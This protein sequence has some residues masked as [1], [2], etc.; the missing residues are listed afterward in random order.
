MAR[1][2]AVTPETVAACDAGSQGPPYASVSTMTPDAGRP[3]MVET[4]RQPSRSL[5]TT[6][7]GRSKKRGPS[8]PALGG[9]RQGWALC[10]LNRGLGLSPGPARHDRFRRDHRV[11]WPHPAHPSCGAR[12]RRAK[13]PAPVQRASPARP[14]GWRPDRSGASR[15]DRCRSAPRAP[16]PSSRRRPCSDASGIGR[17]PR[18]PDGR[19]RPST[20]TPPAEDD[21]E[22]ASGAGPSRAGALCA[23]WPNAWPSKKGGGVSSPRRRVEPRRGPRRRLGSPP[24]GGRTSDDDG[25]FGD[26]RALDLGL[27]LD[28][29]RRLCFVARFD[30]PAFDSFRQRQRRQRAR[31][32]PWSRPPARPKEEKTSRLPV[33]VRSSCTMPCSAACVRNLL[34]LAKP[35][36]ASSNRGRRSRIFRFTSESRTGSRPAARSASSASTST[37]YDA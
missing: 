21:S 20:A 17:W 34:N 23:T 15:R 2:R 29:G 11:R 28:D 16:R 27:R 10:D 12:S 19:P 18:G 8:E 14:A 32:K 7:A 35:S 1:F 4:T 30:V 33:T 3:P 31:R 36:S 37:S 22:E 5:A 13:P 26:R 24:C 9:L 25:L 6:R